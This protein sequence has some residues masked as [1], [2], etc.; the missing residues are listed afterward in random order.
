MSETAWRPLEGMPRGCG[1]PLGSA[2]MRARAEDFRVDEVLGFEP[3]GEGEH[4]LIQVR[5]R[6]ANTHWV[7]GQLAR[8]AGLAPKDVGYAGLKDRHADT[9]QWFTLPL[10]GRPEPDWSGLEQHQVEVTRA[11]RHRRK[12][13]RGALRGNRFRILLRE[14]EADRPL[15]EARLEALRVTGMPNYFG[16]QRFGRDYQN[17]RRFDE[18]LANRRRRIDRQLRGLLI[19]AGRSQLFNEVLAA[20]IERG[21]WDTPLPGDFF[22]LDGSSRSGFPGEAGDAA[23]KARCQSRDIHPSG[24]LWGRGRAPVNGEVAELEQAVLAPFAAWRDG[25]EHLGLMQERRALRVRLDDLEW[26]FPA[27]RELELSF[28]LPAGSYATALLRELLLV[29]APPVSGQAEK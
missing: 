9:T 2:L 22:M 25:L 19:S 29:S 14:L 10:G 12:L 24:P 26:R 7:A 16:E 28:F 23:L 3:D 6:E 1:A 21:C 4:L 17:L 18:F 27:Q 5:K 20:R 15:L 11:H 8:L 13:R